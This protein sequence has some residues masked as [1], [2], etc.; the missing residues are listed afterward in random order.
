MSFFG[1]GSD[2][3]G[4]QQRDA[5]I[6][7]EI[8]KFSRQLGRIGKSG[9]LSQRL[10]FDDASA[11][12]EELAERVNRLLDV[13][14]SKS[15]AG[16]VDAKAQAAMRGQIDALN[17]SQA[18]IE[19][20][21]DGTIIQA[22]PNFLGAL[23]YSLD[24]IRGKHHRIFV[25][26][27]ESESEEYAAFWKKLGNGQFDAGRYKRVRKD[28][29]PIWIQATYNPV[30]DAEGRTLRVV[31]FATD[32]TAEMQSR[33]ALEQAQKAAA[34]ENTRVK[35]ALDNVT[36][37]VMIADNERKIIYLN[38]SVKQMLADAEADIRKELPSFQVAGLQGTCID[39]FHKKP[40][41]QARMI[42][43]L[44]ETYRTEIKL[45]GRTFGLIASPVISEDGARLGTVVEWKDRT[46]ELKLEN[47]IRERE[48]RE[49]LVAAANLRIKNA[50]DN[51]TTNVM[52]ADNERKIIYLNES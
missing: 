46:A 50:L 34:R 7:F 45:G 24:E 29:S 28:G 2:R 42:D 39:S 49:R 31:K 22:N 10:Q 48:E 17:R 41:H 25:G 40:E 4:Q 12:V 36:T 37:N 21:P 35:N 19:F 14:A 44:K 47:E 6:A 18:V 30:L 38:E 5:Q 27:A 16:A 52:I 33:Q 3:G 51:V 23:G 11:P 15:D 20:E 43:A 13:L 32:V 9:D 1:F 26:K 8:N